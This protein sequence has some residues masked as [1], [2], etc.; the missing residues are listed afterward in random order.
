M[1]YSLSEAM[2]W[3]LSNSSGTVICVKGEEQK[4]CS[5]YPDAEAFYKA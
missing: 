1:V 4:E 2:N 3:F 5:C